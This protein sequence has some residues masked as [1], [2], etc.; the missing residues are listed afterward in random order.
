MKLTIL[1]NNTIAKKARKVAVN[2]TLLSKL[3]T[4]TATMT[5]AKRALDVHKTG[6]IQTCP[7]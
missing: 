3:K 5:K 2:K 7:P 4:K 1:S 6:T